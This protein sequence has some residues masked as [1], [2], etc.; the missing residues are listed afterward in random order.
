MLRAIVFDGDDTL[1]STE[2]LYDQARQ[3]AREIVEDAGLDGAAWEDLERRLDVENVARLG[4]G[5]ERFPASCVEAYEE[6]CRRAGDDPD[7][8]VGRKIADAASAVFNEPAP[9][10]ALARE[11]LS[12]LRR[13][14]LR[15]ALLT[16]G[17]AIVQRRRIN[18][19]GLVDLFDVVRVV[20]EKTP[21]AFADVVAHLGVSTGSA[22]SVGNSVRSDVVP[23][24]AAGL[25]AVWVDAH[26]WEYERAAPLDDERVVTADSLAG[27]LEVAAP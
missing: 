26:V 17:D 10:T 15:L 20:D 27:V 11:T 14:G 12:E 18:D 6:L 3:R 2:P 22:L 19:S 1:W 21:E 5:P 16:K 7:P 23:A 8:R 25:G 13:R 4:L 9:L 24:L